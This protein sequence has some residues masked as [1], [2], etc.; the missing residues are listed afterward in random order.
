VLIIFLSDPCVAPGAKGDG[1]LLFPIAALVRGRLAGVGEDAVVCARLV[2]K[3][4]VVE[5]DGAE[6]IQI[7]NGSMTKLLLWH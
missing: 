6:Q 1:L 7:F 3:Q 2:G 5:S 4:W